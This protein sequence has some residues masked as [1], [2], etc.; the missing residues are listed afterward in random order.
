MDANQIVLDFIKELQEQSEDYNDIL[1]REKIL[2][3]LNILTSIMYEH[4]KGVIELIQFVAFGIYLERNKDK[5]S[6]VEIPDIF[7]LAFS[8]GEP[9]NGENV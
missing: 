9:N 6:D 4:N 8:E 1:M 3:T 2:K 5:L 7:K